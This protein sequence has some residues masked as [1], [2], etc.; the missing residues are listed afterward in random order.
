MPKTPDCQ[1]GG[2]GSPGDTHSC[3]V[4]PWEE[5][6]RVLQDPVRMGGLVRAS[7]VLGEGG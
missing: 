4:P 7:W 1:R 2:V 3:P 5:S 6:R